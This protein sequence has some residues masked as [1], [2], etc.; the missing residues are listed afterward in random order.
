MNEQDAIME[1]RRIVW[2]HHITLWEREHPE[3]VAEVRAIIAAWTPAQHL[4]WVES[5][6]SIR[7]LVEA[8]E[9]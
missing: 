3:A 4:A 9:E 7:H 2:E 8:A 1:A 5:M 6:D